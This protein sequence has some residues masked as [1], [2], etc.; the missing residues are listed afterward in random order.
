[1]TRASIE[2]NEVLWYYFPKQSHVVRPIASQGILAQYR[3]LLV[4][5]ELVWRYI[6]SEELG[7]AV[8]VLR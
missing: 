1:V 4:V 6:F 7:R 5:S 8:A 2:P 3:E